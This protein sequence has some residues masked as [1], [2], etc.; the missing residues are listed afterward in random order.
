MA[1]REDS[2][3][4][5]KALIYLGLSYYTYQNPTFEPTMLRVTSQFAKKR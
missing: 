3:L 1:E 2:A 4:N 5:C